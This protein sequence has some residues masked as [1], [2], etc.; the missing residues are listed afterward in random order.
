M[1]LDD[2]KNMMEKALGERMLNHALAVLRQWAAELNKP[3]YTD[4]IYMLSDN[5][6]YIFQYYISGDNP[7]E[8]EEQLNRLTTQTYELLDEMYA[9]MRLKKGLSPYISAFNKDNPQSVAQYFATCA[10]LKESDL[11][12]LYDICHQENSV[13]MAVIAIGALAHNLRTC[14]RTD[15]F[16]T[17]LSAIDSPM[18]LI[19]QQ[20]LVMSI[21]LLVHYD[22]RID[23][24][25][26]LQDEF[27]ELIGDGEMAFMAVCAMVRMLSGNS[28]DVKK[29]VLKDSDIP[30]DIEELF[31]N[32]DDSEQIVDKLNTISTVV[33][34]GEKDYMSEMLNYLPETWV[35]DAIIGEDEEREKHVARIYLKS[36]IMTLMWDDLEEAENIII[37][38]LRSDSPTANDYINYGHCCFLRGD[39]TLA[40]ENYL[41]GKR[42]YKTNKEFL[43]KF[44]PDRHYLAEK[45][46]PLEE[47]YFMED[48]L[49]NI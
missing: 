2:Q 44:R 28:D 45:G 8:R 16:K 33:P 34:E 48:Q 14:F 46:I 24:F 19:A 7:D 43:N 47:I 18:P 15:A 5:A 41:E 25:P 3:E 20:A 30:A 38:N 23:F 39:K 17:L 31:D 32:G 11:D 6:K 27:E 37:D 22:V 10:H 13:A 26:D 4:K 29:I 12:W 35:Y 42:M 1:K 49:V 36:G 21:M 40:Y 9:D